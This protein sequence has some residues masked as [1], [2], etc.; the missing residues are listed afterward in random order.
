MRF[1]IEVK[2]LAVL[3][4][5]GF[6]SYIVIEVIWTAIDCQMDGFLEKTPWTL[7]GYSSIWMGFLGGFVFIILGKLNERKSFRDKLPLAVQSLIGAI[8]ITLLEFIV[9]MILNVHFDLHVWD[10]ENFPLAG[11]FHNQINAFHSSL[12]FLISPVAFWLDDI[13][14]WVFYRLGGCD[15]CNG[16]YSFFWYF[17]HIFKITPP[18]LEERV[19]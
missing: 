4:L 17:K 2:K 16:F 13:I 10:Y 5:I 12:W 8:I 14:R 1:K 19:K 11:Y 3:Y 15:K 6:V 18:K 7:A 9:G